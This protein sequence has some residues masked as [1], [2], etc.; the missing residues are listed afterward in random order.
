MKA[1]KNILLLIIISVISVF[2]ARSQ[3]CSITSKANDIIPDKKCAPVTVSWEVVYRGVDDGGTQVNIVFD[4]DDGTYDTLPA[5]NTDPSTQEWSVT[6]THVYPQGG[7]QCVYYPEASLQVNGVVCTSSAQQQMVTVWDVDTANGGH[8]EINPHI[9]HIC[10]GNDATVTFQDV[11][12]FNC[13]PPVEEDNPNETTRW[14]QW[15]YGTDY[16]INGVLIDG[17]VVTFPDT[18]AV[19]AITPPPVWSPQ[20]P[21]E[22]SLPI[23]VPATAQV[24]QYFE[25]TL[26]NWNYCNP[27]DDPSI[28]GPPADTVNGDHDPVTTTALIIIEPYP[29]ATIDTA[30]PFCANDQPVNLTAA[31]SGGIW[32][33]DG[34][35]DS[36]AG[37]FDPSVA[38]SG[39]HTVYYWVT[40]GYGCEGTDSAQILVYSIPHPNILPGNV[41]TVCPGND[42]QLD[43]NPTPGDGNIVSHLW[44]GDVGNLNATNIQ[45]PIFNSTQSGNYN[46]VYTVTDDNGCSDSE[47][48]TVS[49]S[50]ITV[51]ILP[52]PAD[53]CVNEDF[54]LHGNVSGGTGNYTF[55]WTGEVLPLSSTTVQN[56]VFNSSVADTFSLVLTVTDDNGCTG[57]D[58][59]DVITYPYP[60]P[61]AG[62][63]DSICGLTYQLNATPS[64]AAGHWYLLNG[65][66]TASFSDN[67][68]PTSDVTVSDYGSYEFVWREVNG[69]HCMVEDTV[70][71][72]FV[73]TPVADAGNDVSVCGVS[74]EI[75]ANPSVGTGTWSVVGGPGNGWFENVNEPTTHFNADTFGVYTLAWTEVNGICSNADTI[76]V[77]L[78][79]TP[80]AEFLP[81]NPSGCPPFEVSFNNLT[82]NATNYHWDF[83]D[84]ETSTGENPTHT[85]IN[86]TFGDVTYTVTMIASNGGCSDTTQTQVT[87]HPLPEPH[88]SY[89]N[90]PACSPH[91]VAFTNESNGAVS[92]LWL[93]GDGTP[94]DTAENP[95]H[96][97]YNDTTYIQYYNVRLVAISEYGCTDTASGIVTIY[98]N[99]DVNLEVLPDSLCSPG[100]ATLTAN[101]GYVSYEWNFGDSLQQTTS[102][103]HIN[104]FYPSVSDST[105]VYHLWVR[106]ISPLGCVDTS[107][108]DLVVF[109]TPNADFTTDV[110]SAC[111]SYDLQFTNNS[112]GASVYIWEFGDGDIDTVYNTGLV[113]HHYVNN[114]NAPT[115]FN[116][117]LRAVNQ[118]GCEDSSVRSFVLYPELN[119][120]FEVD[121]VGCSPF[122]VQFDNLTNGA[123]SYHWE[124]GDGTVST[125]E[126]PTHTYVNVYSNPVTYDVSLVVTSGYGCVDTAT[127]LITVYP[128]PDA[129]FSVSPTVMTMPNST[130]H[131]NNLTEGANWNCLWVWGNGDSS[132]VCQPG[133][134]T[135][136]SAGNYTIMLVVSNE[137]CSDTAV[138]VITINPTAPDASFDLDTNE[139]CVPLTVNFTNTSTGGNQYYWN[140]GDG[141]SSNEENPQ[142]IYGESGVFNVQLVVTGDGGTDS[143]ESMVTVHPSPTAFFKVVPTQVSVPGEQ[144]KCY[145]QSEGATSFLWDFGDSVTSTLE[146]PTHEYTSPGT[147]TVSLTVWN[148]YGCTDKYV[149]NDAVIAV[150]AGEIIFPN[151]F[152]PNP[153]GPSGGY[154]DPNDFSNDV[155][156]PVF[157]GVVE[158]E[159]Q[160]FNRWG[161]LIFVSKDPNIGWDGY[162]RGK[163]CKQDVY[164]W[165]VK[166]KFSNGEV[167][168]KVGD[169]TLLR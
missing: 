29:D 36:L 114:S 100:T 72:N 56:P 130:V 132:T 104:H 155:F 92:Y 142:H 41:A 143:Y 126:E 127:T 60:T 69:S 116:I 159:L 156:H 163:L 88:F 103:N 65:P 168:E 71:I 24:G 28:P 33:G 134:Y 53:P 14:T 84:G 5:N 98:P 27:Y 86:N 7:D 144:I 115:T 26:R 102:A 35:T 160:I 30:G 145:N 169:V 85:F 122:T 61:Y 45:N 25:V 123:V 39:L 112:T 66:G 40:N 150:S 38:G 124:F 149:Q 99:P 146:N 90:T 167:I 16:T 42:L 129:Q 106:A 151:A 94:N 164:V 52:H 108:A 19:V 157:K 34:I 11:S 47:P 51:D 2:T 137:H 161:E 117:I 15:I 9:Y 93:F 13:V 57:V 110:T 135:Y 37:T 121:T 166:A 54:Q 133:D 4:W 59:T 20:P 80:F 58:S 12:Q 50:Q 152:T 79:T 44:S 139:G 22:Y 118:F 105:E 101:P 43:G 74:A 140:F 111:G 18:G 119:A 73:E 77:N 107:F 49:V 97:F 75:S 91:S 81:D 78:N 82:S 158:Y 62:E 109:P 23:Y 138:Q 8:M 10:V 147:Y 6:A 68:S 136:G 3:S 131:I 154:Y 70:K 153:S 64:I 21:N 95:V 113:T 32:S 128:S 87:V 1:N 125:D 165:K 89:D 67:T 46:M 17:Q 162:Y 83:G 63:D 55:L 48:V 141:Y 96:T 120:E 76:T 148:E 31:T